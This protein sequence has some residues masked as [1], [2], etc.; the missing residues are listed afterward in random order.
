[1]KKENW[2]PDKDEFLKKGEVDLHKLLHSSRSNLVSDWKHILKAKDF[3]WRALNNSFREIGGIR[4]RVLEIGAGNGWCSAAILRFY[5][6][7]TS[8]YIMEINDFA[9]DKLIPNTL[10]AFDV[11]H[12]DITLVLG[13]FNKIP[14]KEHF[15]YVIAM[16]ALHHSE[17]L[18]NT[19]RSVWKCLKPGGFLLAQEPA[20]VDTTPN[21]FY[22]IRKSGVTV[23]SEGPKVSNQDRSDIFYRDC[24]YFTAMYHAGFD[25]RIFLLSGSFF[26]NLSKKGFFNR[27]I[28][29]RNWFFLL[30]NFLSTLWKFPKEKESFLR[31]NYAI[32]FL[33]NQKPRNI[34]I[35]ASRPKFA[36]M[37]LSP[38]AW[39]SDN[40]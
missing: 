13:S 33:K 40:V 20:M 6:Q 4:G 17:N 32:D 5:P 8:I 37:S 3:R 22:E 25:L 23:F 10:R 30:L 27:F 39:E 1:M 2:R 7:I 31:L 15:D 26:G 16:G 12:K 19:V 36:E 29:L 34:F 14:Y 28:R 11:E 9:L 24:E 18:F 38:T 21:S 35:I